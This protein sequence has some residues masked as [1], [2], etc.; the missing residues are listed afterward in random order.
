M[1]LPETEVVELGGVTIYMLHD[2]SRLD[3]KPRSGRDCGCVYGHSHTP[4][5]EEKN[6]VIFQSGKRRA[7][8]VYA[9]RERGKTC[10]RRGARAS[11]ACVTAMRVNLVVLAVPGIASVGLC[12]VF[13]PKKALALYSM[14]KGRRV[15]AGLF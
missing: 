11:G 12:A 2:L 6:G 8:Q 9:A 15:E 4:K 10:R 3:L 1:E 5:V 14:K 7:A 13:K